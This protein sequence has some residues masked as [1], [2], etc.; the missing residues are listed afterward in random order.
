M[1]DPLTNDTVIQ[2]VSSIADA[3]IDDEIVAL[4]VQ[5][6]TCYGLNRV[7]SRIWELLGSPIRI[8]DLCAQ[9]TKEFDVDPATCERQTVDLLEELR[10][11]GLI[12][13]NQALETHS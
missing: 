8:C 12:T 1:R 2:R 3:A 7:G 5:K 13:L 9:L 6:G 4:D 10:A 11:E